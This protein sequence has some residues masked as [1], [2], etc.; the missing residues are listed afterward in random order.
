MQQQPDSIARI[1]IRPSESGDVFSD[2]LCH[3][4][5]YQTA[6]RLTERLLAKQRT[7]IAAALGIAIEIEAV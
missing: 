7:L 6:Y 2:G 1:R 3:D 4:D 5:A